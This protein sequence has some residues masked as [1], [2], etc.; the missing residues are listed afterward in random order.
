M[1]IELSEDA[2]RFVEAQL[3]EG[4][5]TSAEAVVESA[6]ELLR[7]TGEQYRAWLMAQI[8]PGLDDFANGRYRTLT[9]EFFDAAR[10]RVDSRAART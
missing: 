9:Q 7:T 6:L 4:D 1:R 3:S 2:A 8:Q 10:A 5:F